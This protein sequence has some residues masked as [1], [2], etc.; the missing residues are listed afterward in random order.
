MLY[1]YITVYNINLIDFYFF[2]GHFFP[3]NLIM[4]EQDLTRELTK[5]LAY[6][7]EISE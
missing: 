4:T 1:V 6:R 7:I 2:Q 3:L 5:Y